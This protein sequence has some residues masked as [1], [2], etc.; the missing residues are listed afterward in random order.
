MQIT[1]Y[2]AA[3]EVTGSMH[4]VQINNHRFLLDC[5][6]FQ[7]RRKESE[8]KNKSFPIDPQLIDH[9]ILSHAHM[10]HTGRL[11]LLV[12]ENR[13]LGH[14]Y[15]TRATADACSFLL[16][17]SAHIQEADAQY[18]NY[19]TARNFLTQ[20]K[21]SI[22]DMK[23]SPYELNPISI[24]EVL[25]KHHL[26][27]VKPLYTEQD[28]EKAIASIQ[29]YPYNT[30]LTIGTDITCTFYDAGHILGSAMIILK[31]KEQ[32]KTYTIGFTGD[33]GRFER[34]IVRNPNLTFAPDHTE[35]DLLIME[36]TYGNRFHEPAADIKNKVK[37][38]VQETLDKGGTVLI[39]SFA[40]GRTQEMIY[41]LHELYNEKALNQVPIFVDSP[42][43]SKLTQVFSEHPEVYDQETHQAFLERG[44]NPFLFEK[45][46]YIS[47]V[48]Q[49]MALMRT[50]KPHI[51][52]SSSGMCEAGRILHHLRYR[53]HNSKNTILIVGYMAQHTLGRRI[54]ELGLEYRKSGRKGPVPEVKILNKL[55]PLKANV[56]HINGLSAHAD[57]NEL[58]KF[59]QSSNLKMKRIA[60]VHGEEDQLTGFASCLH[61]HG[62]QVHIPYRNETIAV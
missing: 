60:L 3:R 17:D 44:L 9:V 31:V 1:F 54:L 37:V 49:S 30:P 57:Q 33:I 16:L 53:I 4:M 39:P 36:S 13:F 21:R 41:I 52:I 12:K 48:E 46:H 25:K 59:L 20:S 23:K 45:I 43:A 8:E 47:S 61:S 27:Q 18:L 24:N 19:K 40:Y 42:L 51:V 22:Q 28:A 35:L 6:M 5:G 11:P 10:D 58:I 34:P 32:G 2:G 55:Y 62:Y 29:G 15:C 38:A 26:T 7:G 56:I 50:E 14:I